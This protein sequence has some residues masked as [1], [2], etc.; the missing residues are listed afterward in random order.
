MKYYS[1]RSCNTLILYFVLFLQICPLVIRT[2]PLP[3]EYISLERCTFSF[4]MSYAAEVF[5][6]NLV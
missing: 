2:P 5:N 1:L 3:Q 4:P 6:F